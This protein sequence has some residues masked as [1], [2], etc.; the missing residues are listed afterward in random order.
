[1]SGMV[2]HLTEQFALPPGISCSKRGL[3][4]VVIQIDH[5]RAQILFFKGQDT[6]KVLRLEKDLLRFMEYRRYIVAHVYRGA[7][8]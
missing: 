1:L 2:S 4:E 6:E 7:S 8:R 3:T 5:L